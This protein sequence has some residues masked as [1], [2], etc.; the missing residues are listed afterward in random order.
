MTTYE[1]V[2]YRAGQMARIVILED[3]AETDTKFGRMLTGLEVD[4]EG[5]RAEPDAATLRAAGAETGERRHVIALDVITKRAPLEMDLR[6]AWLVPL[7]TAK[8]P[9]TKADAACQ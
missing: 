7:G 6:Y 8:T 5:I 9:V 2:T 4:R 3:P 1:R